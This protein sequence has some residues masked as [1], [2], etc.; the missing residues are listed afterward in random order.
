M[1]EKESTGDRKG[2]RHSSECLMGSAGDY[3][4]IW[5]HGLFHSLIQLFSH[6]VD[7]PT[8]RILPSTHT[9]PCKTTE[10]HSKN[11]NVMA[12]WE[13]KRAAQGCTLENGRFRCVFPL[14]PKSVQ[15]RGYH[16]F[17]FYSATFWLLDGIHFNGKMRK[18]LVENL[19][20]KSQIS[21]NRFTKSFL[22]R[23]DQNY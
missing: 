4:S 7:V 23:P 13:G 9:S 20:K 12:L 2:D 11:M 6:L 14:V 18:H 16:I 21:P 17:Q 1:G 15:F 8:A 22:A 10:S 3:W 5:E 19:K